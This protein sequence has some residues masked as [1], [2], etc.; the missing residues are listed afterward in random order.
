MFVC[1]LS[2]RDGLLILDQ[3]DDVE[4]GE[5]GD[6]SEVGDV[7]EVGEGGTGGASKLAERLL[8]VDEKNCD[9]CI[10]FR[11]GRFGVDEREYVPCSL[12]GA[13]F[14][15]SA[16]L[17]LLLAPFKFLIDLKA[18]DALARKLFDFV[19]PTSPIFSS[20]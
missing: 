4:V 1:S 20:C 14:S 18:L 11:R 10:D 3:S 13:M 12:I 2:V 7:G 19:K 16:C 8:R 9:S 17:R 6:V 15:V 5:V